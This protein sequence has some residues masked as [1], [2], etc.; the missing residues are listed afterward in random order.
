MK[1]VF[2]GQVTIFF[3]I[4]SLS[5]EKKCSQAFPFNPFFFKKKFFQFNPYCGLRTHLPI[6]FLAFIQVPTN[7]KFRRVDTPV[8]EQNH[9]ADLD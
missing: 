4:L 9:P 2:S 5:K 7:R 1:P 8:A 3:V 6:Y